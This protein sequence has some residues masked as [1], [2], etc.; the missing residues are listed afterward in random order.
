MR[1]FS[2]IRGPGSPNLHNA[3]ARETDIPADTSPVRPPAFLHTRTF[4]LMY[5]ER[6]CYIPPRVWRRR[7]QAGAARLRYRTDVE[8]ADKL[9]T[10]LA[11]CCSG[12]RR[13]GRRRLCSAHHAASAATAVPGV[14][15]ERACRHAERQRPRTR[16]GI[17]ASL[18]WSVV[19]TRQHG[20]PSSHCSRMRPRRRRHCCRMHVASRR[21]NISRCPLRFC[22]VNCIPSAQHDVMA[23]RRRKRLRAVAHTV[24]LYKCIIYS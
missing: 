5:D 16:R 13:R 7:R 9:Q 8:E 3:I 1:M 11:T 2:E 4:P 18:R 19:T 6:V 23:R 20:A 17:G 14:H 24:R 10:L 22:S 15:L 21:Q 12:W